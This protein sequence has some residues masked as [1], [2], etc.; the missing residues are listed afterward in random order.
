MYIFTLLL[1]LLASSE[2]QRPPVLPFTVNSFQ[3]IMRSFV[4]APAGRSMNLKDIIIRHYTN[5]TRPT[6]YPLPE[7]MGLLEDKNFNLTK[8]TLLYAH[9]YVELVSDESVVTIV[10]AYLKNGCYNILVLDWS[11][12]AFGNYVF[13][14]LDTGPIGR[15]TARAMSKLLVSGL[16]LEGL[17]FVGHSLG[18]HVLASAARIL[19]EMGF[20]IPR[21]TGL[22]PAYPG[23]YP[24]ILASPMSFKDAKFVDIIH[25]DGGG[26]GTPTRVGHADFWPNGGQ[27]KQPGCIAATVSLTAEDFCSHWRSWAYYAESVVGTLFP[28]RKC[29]DYDSFLKGECRKASVGLMGLQATY[30][31]RGNFYLRTSASPPYSLGK[32]GAE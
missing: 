6:S 30:K 1:A 24:P 23:F 14:S 18:T 29:E 9:G 21:L 8:P 27:A 20:P 12:M 19:D 10:K 11:N 25:T 22:D 26:Y 5:S 15:V 28:A 17:H 16:S 7:I 13:V 3:Q 31:N 4:N 32:R 2:C